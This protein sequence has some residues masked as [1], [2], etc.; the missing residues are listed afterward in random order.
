MQ[1]LIRLWVAAFLRGG[2]LGARAQDH[3]EWGAD[4][5]L[6]DPFAFKAAVH[7]G[8]DALLAAGP[9]AD[10]RADADPEQLP[11]VS[12]VAGFLRAGGG[13]RRRGQGHSR[14]A[15]KMSTGGHIRAR[16]PGAWELKYDIGRDP[17]TGKRRIR[18]KTVRGKKSDAQRELRNLLGTVDKGVLVDAGKMTLGQW[19]EQWLAECKHTVAPKT[20]QE[21]AAYVRPHIWRR[22]LGSPLLLAK[23][24]PAH[25]QALLLREPLTSGRLDGKGGLSPQT[26]PH[27]RPGTMH[28]ALDPRPEVAP[29]R[30][31]TRSMTSTRR[32]LNARKWWS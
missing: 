14:G 11:A 27:H 13:A 24:A 3:P 19:L 7:A 22:Q 5:W 18:Y 20:H 32:A 25:I 12:A 4:Q 23:L 6:S 26:M 1:E 2:A 16:G 21:R 17:I 10:Y 28:T 31:S 30:R 29:D 9:S 15:K 8:Q